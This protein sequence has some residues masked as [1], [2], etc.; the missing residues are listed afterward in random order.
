MPTVKM[1]VRPI[2]LIVGFLALEVNAFAHIA[3]PDASSTIGLL[4]IALA[5]LCI[6]AR[7]MHR[8]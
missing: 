8:R 1:S 5:A 4:G 3:V 7:K 2:L 6:V